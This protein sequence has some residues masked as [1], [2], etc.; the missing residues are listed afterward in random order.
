MILY[1]VMNVTPKRIFKKERVNANQNV[2]KINPNSMEKI[3][4]HQVR[5]ALQISGLTAGINVYQSPYL[6]SM[7]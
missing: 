2:Q 1:D 3:V 6:A 5:H 7:V 4:L